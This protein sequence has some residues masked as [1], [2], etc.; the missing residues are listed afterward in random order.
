MFLG[1]GGKKLVVFG[2]GPLPVFARVRLATG[3]IRGF[4]IEAL[5]GSAVLGRLVLPC[6]RGVTHRLGLSV[7][8]VLPNGDD[9]L[10][11]GFLG[12]GGMGR[13]GESLGD[14]TRRDLWL[15][16]EFCSFK[17]EKFSKQTSFW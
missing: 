10:K 2:I 9:G 6:L 7:W 16:G 12:S 14:S 13:I 17:G 8:V 4:G 1:E 3:L 15:S 5:L 11:S